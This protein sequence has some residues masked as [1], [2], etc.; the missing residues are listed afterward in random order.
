M[1]RKSKVLCLLSVIALILGSFSVSAQSINIDTY[2]LNAGFPQELIDEMSTPQKEYI[3]SHSVGED[4][5]F[6]GYQ[7]KEYTISNEGA[8]VEANSI[9]PCG[10]SISSSDMTISVVGTRVSSTSGNVY[11]KVFPCFKWHTHTTVANDSFAMSMYPNW[12]AIP[13]ERNFRLH[14]LNN[15]GQSVQYVD[16]SPTQASSTGYVYKIPSDTGFMQ[17]LYEGYAYYNIN[18]SS[19]TALPNITLYYAHDTT[20]SFNISYNLNIGPA[21][22]SLIG[23]SDNLYIMTDN[24]YVSGLDQ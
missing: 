23:D 8:F 18:K 13:G 22:I 7:Q 9:A 4:I 12:T 16:L 6:C 10:G 19:D 5:D 21:Q 1:L 20:S 3:Y 17:A 11:Y 2:L 24:Y 15:A 14:L